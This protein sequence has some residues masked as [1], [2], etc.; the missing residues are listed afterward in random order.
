MIPHCRFSIIGVHVGEEVDILNTLDR[1][2]SSGT[3]CVSRLMTSD[4]VAGLT[5]QGGPANLSLFFEGLLSISFSM[6]RTC[7]CMNRYWPHAS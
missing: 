2:F 5:G 3:V 7:A 6:P 1:D 4:E